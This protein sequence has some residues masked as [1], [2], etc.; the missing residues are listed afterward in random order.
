[1]VYNFFKALL[2]KNAQAKI[3]KE[4]WITSGL[5]HKI[6]TLL[7]LLCSKSN[8]SLRIAHTCQKVTPIKLMDGQNLQINAIFYNHHLILVRVRSLRGEYGIELLSSYKKGLR[9]PGSDNDEKSEV[10]IEASLSSRLLFLHRSPR[11][12]SVSWRKLRKSP[13][14]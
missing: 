8:A 1:M 14:W 9:L 5:L 13:E 10:A 6:D 7:I 12:T 4:A 2:F 3:F 11:A